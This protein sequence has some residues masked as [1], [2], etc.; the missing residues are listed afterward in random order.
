MEDSK[1]SLLL[2]NCSARLPAEF[3]TSK[4]GKIKV[5]CLPKNTMALIQPLSRGIIQAFKVNYRHELILSLLSFN[6]DITELKKKNYFER[7][8][9]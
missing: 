6:N 8:G 1:P 3:L 2:D 7:D 9:F 5:L 4:D